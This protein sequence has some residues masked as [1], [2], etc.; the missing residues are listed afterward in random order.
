MEGTQVGELYLVSL[1]SDFAAG[2]HQRAAG[3]VRS[4]NQVTQG[5]DLFQGGLGSWQQ[6]KELSMLTV[7]GKNLAQ[8]TG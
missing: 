1:L 3:K 4:R 5:K 6:E 7:S 2:S 8:C